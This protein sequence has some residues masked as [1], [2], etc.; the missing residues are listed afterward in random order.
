MASPI[1]VIKYLMQIFK[2]ANAV[3]MEIVELKL[4]T[5]TGER[6]SIHHLASLLVLH[7]LRAVVCLKTALGERTEP[8][9]SR[10]SILKSK[11]N[12]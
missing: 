10:L 7:G 8:H 12:R 11:E 6:G 4:P 9:T 1:I 2:L 5:Y 3:V